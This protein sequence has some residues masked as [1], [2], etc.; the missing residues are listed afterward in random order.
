MVASVRFRF[1][2]STPLDIRRGSGTYVGIQLLAR[3]L[4]SLGHTVAFETPQRHFPIYTL[5]RLWFNRTVRPSTEFDCSVGFDMDGYRA[6]DIA[7]LKGV[8]A[9]EAR[10]ERGFT[11]GT[12]SLQA[13][14]EKLHVE[15]ARRVLA[16][17]RYSAERARE[18]YRLSSLPEVVPELIDLNEW[19][20]L[21]A[22]VEKPQAKPPAPP[23]SKF[24]AL[25]VGRFYRRKRIDVLLRA[26]AILR[27]RIPGL[28]VRLVGNGPRGPALRAIARRLKLDQS[29]VWLGDVSRADL[30]REYNR[31]SV[32]CLPSVQEGFGIVLLEAMAAGKPIVASRAAAIPETAPHAA[33]V[34]A[35]QPEALAQGIEY[36]YASS[37]ARAMQREAGMQWVERFDAPRVARLF[38]NAV[39]GRTATYTSA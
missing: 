4:E 33:L 38:L 22:E 1:L 5:E 6:A 27:S 30:A 13:R 37:A 8:I 28:E 12:M 17:S 16:T 24:S 15:R 18:F 29:V 35:D 2:T 20:R 26:A 31:A 36:L 9:D 14:C 7:S 3:G 11:W 39:A 34:E 19:R 23:T 25:F 10:F 21:L 32:F